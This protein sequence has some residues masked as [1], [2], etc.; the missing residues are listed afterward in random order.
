M[1]YQPNYTLP[2][3]WVE[4]IREGGLDALPDLIRVLLNAA[5]HA[6]RQLYLGVEPYQR[7]DQRRDQANGYKPKT[8]KTRL[9]DITFDVS[10]RIMSNN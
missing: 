5:M 6:E 9:G 10:L 7:S 1:T 2:P 4:A 3:D 8:I